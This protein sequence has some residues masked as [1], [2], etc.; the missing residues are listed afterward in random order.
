MDLSFKLSLSGLRAD[1]QCI[2]FGKRVDG[3]TDASCEEQ[4]GRRDVSDSTALLTTGTLGC[5][6]RA[7]A[8]DSVA[9]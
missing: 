6:S 2:V 4:A 5:C 7:S 1:Y 9:E 8:G 3:D